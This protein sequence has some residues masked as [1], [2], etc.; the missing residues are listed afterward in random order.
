MVVSFVQHDSLHTELP[1]SPKLCGMYMT[2]S[3]LDPE[4]GGIRHGP[5]SPHILSTLYAWHTV[6]A[7]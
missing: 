4:L 5:H 3:M 2:A 1:V 7:Q 6:A